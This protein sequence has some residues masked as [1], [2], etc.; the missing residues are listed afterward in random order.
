MNKLV[1]SVALAF[2]C[3]IA[4]AATEGSAVEKG[5]TGTEK[6][7]TSTDV[8]DLWWNPAESGWGLQ[9][10]QES[11]FV[12]ATLFIYGQDGRPT[13]ATA[14]MQFVG[15]ATVAGRVPTIAGGVDVRWRRA[16]N[17]RAKLKGTTVISLPHR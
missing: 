12:F 3:A 15:P 17:R 11:G 13:W 5:P 6:T 4:F 9:M 1:F 16:A 8:S 7:A 14:E 2:Q 10:V